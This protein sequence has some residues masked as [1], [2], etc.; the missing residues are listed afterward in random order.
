MKPIVYMMLG[1]TGSGKTTFAYTL[2]K[3]HHIDVLSLDKEYEQQGGNLRDHRWNHEAATAAGNIIKQKVREYITSNQSVV[4]D[5][6]PWT[7]NE[8]LEYRQFIEGL[9]AT[10]VIYYFDVSFEELLKRLTARK[11]G[12]IVTS[13]M[14]TDFFD[15]FEPPTSDE[16]F[17]IA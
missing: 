16:E 11:D 15:K 3:E 6:C 5:F 17:I 4:L 9:G 14:L 2:G 1:V 13:D 8:R 10:C 12:Q 7:K